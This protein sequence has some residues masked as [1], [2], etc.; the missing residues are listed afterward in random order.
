MQVYRLCSEYEI[1]I[2]LNTHDFS[3]ISHFFYPSPK[4]NNHKY[5]PHQRYLHFFQKLSDILYQDT[6]SDKILC[7]YNIPDEILNKYIGLGYYFDY[8]NYNNL[9]FV[10][11][12]A[13]PN[14]EINFPYLEKVERLKRNIDYEDFLNDE[15]LM[16]LT[17][18]IY[19]K[20]KYK[21]KKKVRR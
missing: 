5:Q 18:T 21:E 8:I 2:I 11:E 12:Y 19:L 14:V 15:N 9:Q 7:T 16:T 6:T 10:T 17:T 3:K 20:E 1:N 13:I 4:M